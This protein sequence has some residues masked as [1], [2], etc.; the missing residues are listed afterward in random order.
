M[1]LTFLPADADRAREER[2][3]I[4]RPTPPPVGEAAN[5]MLPARTHRR[6]KKSWLRRRFVTILEGSFTLAHIWTMRHTASGYCC[7]N[8]SNLP[9]SAQ[10]GPSSIR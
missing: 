9:K 2:P 7:P 3:E 1:R 8:C 5:R 6:M 10:H 4:D